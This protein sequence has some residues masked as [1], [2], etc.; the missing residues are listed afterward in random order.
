MS[1]TVGVRKFRE[2]LRYYLDLV[3]DGANACRHHGAGPADRAPSGAVELRAARFRGPDPAGKKP[4]TPI[5]PEE[6]IRAGWASLAFGHHHRRSQA[7]ARLNL[8]LDASAWAKVFVAEPEA[9][10]GRSAVGRS[11]RRLLPQPRL[12]RGEG[13]DRTADTRP[14]GRGSVA[15]FST[16][17]GRRSRRQRSAIGSLRTPFG[18]STSTGCERWTRCTSRRRLEL[19][20]PGLVLGTWDAELRRAAV[21]EGLSVAP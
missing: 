6:K 11:R 21:A 7:G 9:E 3:K 18:S 2:N 8:Y 5:R 16:I 4:K 19:D 20:R 17:A 10:R 14:C 15:R 12:P 13:G 1:V